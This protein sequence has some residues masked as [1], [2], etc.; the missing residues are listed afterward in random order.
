MV[1]G[2]WSRWKSLNSLGP[3][4][5]KRTAWQCVFLWRGG[6]D[7]A[8]SEAYLPGTTLAGAAGE[9]GETG[10]TGAAGLVCDGVVGIGAGEAGLVVDPG[11]EP[12]PDPGL[13]PGVC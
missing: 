3:C 13:A 5:G 12:E 8:W 4:S 7:R 9:A 10:E 2:R 11:L 6:L 1:S